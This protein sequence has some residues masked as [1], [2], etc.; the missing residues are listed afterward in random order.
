MHPVLFHVGDFPVAT[1]GVLL[2]TG[3]FVGLLLATWRARLDGMPP[4]WAWDLGILTFVTAVVGARLEYVRVNLPTF[5]ADPARIFAVREGGLVFYGGFVLTVLGYAAYARFRRRGVLEITDLMAA[6]AAFGITIG[7]AG[8]LAAGCCYG[9]PTDSWWHVV[10]PA[11]G[12]APAGIPLVPTQVHEVAAQF[13]IGLLLWFLPV[14]F[15][16]QRTVLLFGLYGI[17]RF[18]NE[19]FRNDPRGTFLGTT[20]STGQGTALCMVALALMIGIRQFRRV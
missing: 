20:L 4:D 19:L 6:P 10:F 3:I 5:L 8:C 17:F 11:E 9:R 7:R 2:G 16:G 12:L 18:V 14:R 1:Y 15:T 13:C